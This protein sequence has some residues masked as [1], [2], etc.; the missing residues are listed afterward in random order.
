M[1]N[2]L[3]PFK[4]RTILYFKWNLIDVVKRTILKFRGN[5]FWGISS[6]IKLFSVVLIFNPL[7]S[8]HYLCSCLSQWDTA[9]QERFRTITSSYYRGAHGIIVVYD[10]TDQVGPLSKVILP[11]T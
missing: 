1:V 5:L 9:G 8:F 4:T 2:Y 7:P 3:V 11:G 10:V 6:V